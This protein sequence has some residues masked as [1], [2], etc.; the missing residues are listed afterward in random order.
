VR[1]VLY[2]P[3]KILKAMDMAPKG[4]L[5]Y[6][7]IETL[8]QVESLQKWGRGFLPA[9]SVIQDKAKRMF[10]MGQRVC[11]IKQVT[12]P[13]GEMFSFEYERTLRLI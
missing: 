7:G 11:P 5:N 6:R 3:W 4:S 10:E 1:Q 9:T 12:S 13:L 2:V 8:W